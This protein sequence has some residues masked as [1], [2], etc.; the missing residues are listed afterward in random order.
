MPLYVGKILDSGALA[1]AVRF[2]HEVLDMSVLPEKHPQVILTQLW[3]LS[4]WQTRLGRT[5]RV[6]NFPVS[7]PDGGTPQ[8]R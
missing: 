4:Y 1:V 2:E 7:V 6:R 8:Y 3:C 5:R